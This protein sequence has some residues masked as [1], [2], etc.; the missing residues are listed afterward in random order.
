MITSTDIERRQVVDEQKGVGMETFDWGTALDRASARDMA[1]I[2]ATVWRELH[3][4]GL[5][6]IEASLLA[7]A[8]TWTLGIAHP[9]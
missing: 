9:G 5:D 4:R 6:Q 8:R 3:N 2:V 1:S 7:V